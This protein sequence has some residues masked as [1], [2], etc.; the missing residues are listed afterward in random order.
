M[1]GSKEEQ[2]AAVYRVANE[3]GAADL[4]H[5]E[6]PPNSCRLVRRHVEAIAQLR[7]SSGV[8]LVSVIVFGNH[9]RR[10]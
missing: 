5:D 8:A 3:P 10:A 7:L 4:S 2:A 9:K 6:I 1:P